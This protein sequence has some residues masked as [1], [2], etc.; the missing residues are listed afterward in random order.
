MWGEECTSDNKRESKENEGGVSFF[1][2]R[3][4]EEVEQRSDV[5]SISERSSCPEDIRETNRPVPR[6]KGVNG[7][8]S[9]AAETE[10]SGGKVIL[11]EMMKRCVEMQRIREFFGAIN[12]SSAYIERTKLESELI[13]AT[14][15][16]LNNV[17]FEFSF[18]S[19]E[20]KN[21]PILK[22]IKTL[23]QLSSNDAFGVVGSTRSNHTV[24]FDIDNAVHEIEKEIEKLVQAQN[25]EPKEMQPSSKS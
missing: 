17:S 2:W 24:R 15:S 21:D 14:E 3:G 5:A 25:G 7:R 11:E 20:P 19:A 22:W 4:C 6:N 10:G 16:R 9:Q 13:S 8:H 18:R 23:G 1:G 12:G